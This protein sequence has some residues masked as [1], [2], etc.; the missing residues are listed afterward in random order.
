MYIF[1]IMGYIHTVVN[2]RVTKCSFQQIAISDNNR[3][4]FFFYKYMGNENLIKLNIHKDFNGI[5]NNNNKIE[6]NLKMNCNIIK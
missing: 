2:L 4:Y 5:I 1:L 3:I 6:C